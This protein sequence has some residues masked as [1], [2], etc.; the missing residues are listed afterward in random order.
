MLFIICPYTPITTQFT[1]YIICRCTV[2]GIYSI[3]QYTP[4]N[5]ISCLLWNENCISWYGTKDIIK[6]YQFILWWIVFVCDEAGGNELQE[7]TCNDIN[8]KREEPLLI[9]LGSSGSI[10]STDWQ[11]SWH[12]FDFWRHE[13]SKQAYS[14]YVAI[15][16]QNRAIL[17]PAFPFLFLPIKYHIIYNNNYQLLASPFGIREIPAKRGTDENLKN[18]FILRFF[19]F[20]KKKCIKA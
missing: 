20:H 10:G 6:L 3:G 12:A 1:K 17:P 19:I 18:H 9:K 7:I 14:N 4:N 16:D 5:I 15:Q 11:V 2:Y 8:L 13:A